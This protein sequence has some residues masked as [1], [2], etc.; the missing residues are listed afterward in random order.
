MVEWNNEFNV[1]I[2]LKDF[3]NACNSYF[4][5]KHN[6]EVTELPQPQDDEHYYPDCSKVRKR[7]LQEYCSCEEPEEVFARDNMKT[8]YILCRKCHKEVNPTP[9]EEPDR[10]VDETE[11]EELKSIDVDL[12]DMGRGETYKLFDVGEKLNELIRAFNRLKT[13]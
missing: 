13:E 2:T 8:G 6:I 3:Q 11:I 4:G 9:P 7:E 12:G 1:D 5:Y 10:R